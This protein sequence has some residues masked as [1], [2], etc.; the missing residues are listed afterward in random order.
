VRVVELKGEE[1][2]GHNQEEVLAKVNHLRRIYRASLAE[3][4]RHLLEQYTVQDFARKIV[5]VGSVGTRCFAVALKGVDDSDVLLLQVKEAHASVIEEALGSL[6]GD[7]PIEHHGQRVVMGQHMLQS[8]S[9]VFL[10]FSYDPE[11]H[12]RHYYWRQLKDMKGGVEVDTLNPAQMVAYAK[13]CAWTLAR[14]HAKASN[15]NGRAISYYVGDESETSFDEA[16]LDFAKRY[17]AINRADFEAFTAA[18]KDGKL[19]VTEEKHE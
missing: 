15:A 2:W 19:E 13:L 8:S 11:H 1:L 18:I 14:A 3:S 7:K 17:A 9:D 12:K 5:G 4:R 16:M 6:S 10:G